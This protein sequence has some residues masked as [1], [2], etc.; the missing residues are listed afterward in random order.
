MMFIFSYLYLEQK[1]RARATLKLCEEMFL[2]RPSEDNIV[3]L[4]LP[5]VASVQDAHRLH[6][7]L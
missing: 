1:S 5:H 4:L 2:C 7:S 3:L 6:T